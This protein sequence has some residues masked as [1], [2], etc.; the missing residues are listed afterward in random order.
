MA[1]GLLYVTRSA[2]AQAVKLEGD[3][4]LEQFKSELARE[5]SSRREAFEKEQSSAAGI[6]TRELER[7]RAELTLEAEV[8]RQAAAKKVEAVL[9]LS[10]AAIELVTVIY[11]S[12]LPAHEV[13]YEKHKCWIL[14]LLHVDILLSSDLR[15]ELQRFGDAV[16]RAMSGISLASHKIDEAR[17]NAAIAALPPGTGVAPLSQDGSDPRALADAER[18][19]AEEALRQL[20][21]A[22]RRELQIS[23][24]GEGPLVAAN[25]ARMQRNGERPPPR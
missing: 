7:F 13:R 10:G 20:F 5:A 24:L 4:E 21:E 1:A 22:F 17:F 16:Q 18:K 19:A 14:A 15:S 3:K 12:E 8:R 6:A 25:A 9:K 23:P 2:I 11:F